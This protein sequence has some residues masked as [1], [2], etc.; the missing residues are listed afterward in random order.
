MCI[1]SESEHYRRL[2]GQSAN[3]MGA[4]YWQLNSIWPAPTWSSLE[5]GGRWKLLHYSASHFFAPLLI[6]SYVER[7]FYNVYLVSDYYKE[8]DG[9]Y[10]IIAYDWNGNILQDWSDSISL[11]NFASVNIFSENIEELLTEINSSANNTFFYLT[12]NSQTTNE[13]VKNVYF[14]SSFADINLP[15]ATIT[16]SSVQQVNSYEVKMI[17][18][19]NT[20]APFVFIS[21]EYSGRFSD[22]GFLLL[23]NSS[24]PLEF[25]AFDSI[26][27]INN[28]TSSLQTRT[29]RDTYL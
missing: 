15:N 7:Q 6:S 17:I 14:P 28:F 25:F 10:S 5:Y 1:S 26:D 23:P 22:N 27:D 12:F 20:V 24:L 18:T 13:V 19:S 16:I 29:V 3:T 9:D 2:K 8:I 4:L 11:P 21:T